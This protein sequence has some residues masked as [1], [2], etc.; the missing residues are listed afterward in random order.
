MRREA[1]PRFPPEG[2]FAGQGTWVVGMYHRR[3]SRQGRVPSGMHRHPKGVLGGE[4]VHG[5]VNTEPVCSKC[6]L[7]FRQGETHFYLLCA[8]AEPALLQRLRSVSYETRRWRPKHGLYALSCF[9]TIE[10]EFDGALCSCLVIVRGPPKTFGRKCRISPAGVLG[11]FQHQVWRRPRKIAGPKRRT[12]MKDAGIEN[13]KSQHAF[14]TREGR[15]F[16]H[17]VYFGPAAWTL[18]PPQ[19]NEAPSVFA[20]VRSTIEV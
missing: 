8:T 2:G 11:P 19:M 20:N 4:R 18:M 16:G 13:N 6:Q 7:T 17:K 5:V 14:A 9:D 12:T 10:S 15:R 1:E 3:F